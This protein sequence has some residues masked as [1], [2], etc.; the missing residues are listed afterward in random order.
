MKLEV[1]YLPSEESV[2]LI[3]ST[4]E[5]SSSKDLTI[6]LSILQTF[7]ADFDMDPELENEELQELIDKARSENKDNLKFCLSLDGIELEIC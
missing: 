3:I 1:N 6:G 2:E 5:F 7:A 4:K